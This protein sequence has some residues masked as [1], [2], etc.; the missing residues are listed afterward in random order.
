MDSARPTTDA[1]ANLTSEWQTGRM[2]IRIIGTD[3]PGISGGYPGVQVGL[4][5]GNTVTD[6]VSADVASVTF[7]LVVSVVPTVDGPDF[8]G[9]SV[10]GK[11]GSRF[12]YLV[13]SRPNPGGA[14]EMFRRAKL[15]LKPVAELLASSETAD[16]GHPDVIGRL[17]LTDAKGGPVCASV[18]PP[19]IHW[20]LG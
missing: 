10:F 20:Q 6:P 5:R 8:R 1:R 7:D 13:W 2:R 3:L 4:Q 18:W 16:G 19:A 11:R 9:P 14:P 12:L 17:A 15:L